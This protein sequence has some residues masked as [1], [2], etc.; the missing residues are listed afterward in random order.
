M[1]ED[2]KK[3]KETLDELGPKPANVVIDNA[4]QEGLF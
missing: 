4:K 2:M 3:L 1:W